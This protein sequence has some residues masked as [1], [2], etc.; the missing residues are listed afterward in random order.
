MIL[1]PWIL[2]LWAAPIVLGQ[3]RAYLP[4]VGVTVTVYEQTTQNL[5]KC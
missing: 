4:E 1:K 5:A 2:T 3:S